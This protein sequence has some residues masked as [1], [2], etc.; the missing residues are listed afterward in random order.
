MDLTELVSHRNWPLVALMNVTRLDPPQHPIATPLATIRN[1]RSLP[2]YFGTCETVYISQMPAHRGGCA[3]L[4]PAGLAG[5]DDH[6]WKA[7]L[8]RDSN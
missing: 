7:R 5:L 4:F 3:E 1:V 6:T 2:S 8:S